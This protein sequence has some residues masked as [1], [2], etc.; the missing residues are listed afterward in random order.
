MTNKKSYFYGPVPSRRLGFS[1]GLELIPKKLCS[2]NCLYCQAGRTRD[3]SLKRFS[4]VKISQL[5]KELSQVLKRKPKIDYITISGSGEPTLH[6][7]LD[8][9]IAVL[10][11]TT[12]NKYPICVIT[13]SSLLYRKKVRTELAQADLIMPSLD[14]V[15]P[16]LFKKINKPIS[17]LSL[18]KIIQGLIALRREFKGKIYLEIMLLG[19]VNDTISE[20]KKFKQ[21]IQKIKPDRV[22]L[23]L[24]VRPSEN[25]VVLPTLL[26]LKQFKKILGRRT[27]AIK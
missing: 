24:P 7:G 16:A 14:A 8:K 3:K 1:L 10:K 6:K 12:K 23:N 20:A 17:G 22:L 15:G 11:K 5:K 9:I 25:K 18:N 26:R 21:V 27:Q 4:Y 13:N 19:G 2:F